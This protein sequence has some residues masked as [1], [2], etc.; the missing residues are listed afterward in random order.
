MLSLVKHSNATR[1]HPPLKWKTT[2]RPTPELQLSVP[3]HPH[4]HA[5]CAGDRAQHSGA[6]PLPPHEGLQ[7]L[8]R[9]HRRLK[10]SSWLSRLLLRTSRELSAGE[11]DV[12][13]RTWIQHAGDN[14][15][16]ARARQPPCERRV[17]GW[18]LSG[19]LRVLRVEDS[20]HLLLWHWHSAQ[21]P[22]V[23]GDAVSRRAERICESVSA[24]TFF[25]AF[26]L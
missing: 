15:R 7:P 21:V 19:C 13:H 17:G 1:V 14:M 6:A 11:T 10:R 24:V 2:S 12:L 26:K 4:L 23:D 22:S 5:A 16:A 8:T 3:Q 25:H 9:N 20:H 18:L